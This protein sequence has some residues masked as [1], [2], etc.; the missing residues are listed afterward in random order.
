MDDKEEFVELAPISEVIKEMDKMSVILIDSEKQT[1]LKNQFENRPFITQYF[2]NLQEYQNSN[3]YKESKGAH[4][5][6]KYETKEIEAYKKMKGNKYIFLDHKGQSVDF[7][8]HDLAD[9][10]IEIFENLNQIEKKL[11]NLFKRRMSHFII[12]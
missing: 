10:G 6:A 1:L 4:L 9:A 7:E 3:I 12:Y 2:P 5:V 11:R 8:S